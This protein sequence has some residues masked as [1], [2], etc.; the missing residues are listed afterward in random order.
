MELPKVKN[1]HI[2]ERRGIA[3]VQ[4]Y[5]ARQ[6]QIWREIGVSDVGIDGQLEFVDA[7]GFATG[8][9]VAVQVKAGPAY[10][11]HR[12]ATG[13]KFYPEGK[14]RNYW[15]SFPLPVL[16]VLHDVAA[17]RSFWTDAR[18]ALRARSNEERA[19]I[20]IPAIN[21]LEAA[22]PISLFEHAGVQAQEFIPSID[23]VLRALLSAKSNEGTFPLTYFDLFTHGLTNIC[24]S[25][26]YGTDVINNAVEFNLDH[27]RSEFGMGMGMGHVE[28]EFSFGFVKFLLAQNLA[29]VDFSDCLIDWVDRSMHPHFVAPLT[30]R[31]RSLVELIGKHEE[32]LVGVGL[33]PDGGFLRVAQEGLFQMSRIGSYVERFPR[34][35]AFQDAMKTAGA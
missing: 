27:N 35:R 5:A 22:E 26:Y 33:L 10:F 23:D 24:R 20:E 31:G 11:I 7:Q 6:G 4:A 32:R 2:Q 12:T 14:H 15:E 1:T 29:Q 8:R 25:I 28:H 16:L 30:S 19:Y 13:W 17:E 3:A 34:I 21:V 18:Q 9:T